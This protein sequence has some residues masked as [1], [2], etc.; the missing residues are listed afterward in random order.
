MQNDLHVIF[1]L[2]PTQFYHILLLCAQNKTNSLGNFYKS[3]IWT[4]RK[5]REFLVFI[6]SDLVN[7]F[8]ARQNADWL[9]L[10]TVKYYLIAG[11]SHIIKLNDFKSK[12][13]I[14]LRFKFSISQLHFLFFFKIFVGHMSI[15]GATDTP[16][17]D[18]W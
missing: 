11:S 18:F 4:P 5:P 2:Y 7:R 8:G 10:K 1:T 6:C 13:A 15:F 12:R 17:S 9:V 16:V 3:N 14:K